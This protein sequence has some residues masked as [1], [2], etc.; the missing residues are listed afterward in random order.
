MKIS[1]AVLLCLIA[2]VTTAIW[3]AILHLGT[4]ALGI[5]IGAVW[6]AAV[7]VFIFL[8]LLLGLGMGVL[9]SDSTG[10]EELDPP[11]GA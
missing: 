1:R 4:R 8:L 10:D 6:L 11:S 7:L 5:P 9:A 3:G 2:L